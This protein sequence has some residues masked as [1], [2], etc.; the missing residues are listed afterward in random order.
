MT[1]IVLA[2]GNAGKIEEL[3][4]MLEG[5]GIRARAQSH[6]NVPSV[7]E[8]GSTFVENAIIKARHAAALTGMS[9]VGDDSGIEVMALNGA[10]GVYSARFAGPNATDEDNNRKLLE[11]M[12]DI[13]ADQ[14]QARFVCVMVFMRHANDATPLIA[15]GTFEGM[16]LDKIHVGGRGFGYDPVFYVPE[17]GCTAAE[18]SAEVKNRISHR[19][20]ALQLLVSE[21]RDEFQLA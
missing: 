20:K 4:Q 13:P 3:N 14:R 5:T 16:I 12:K 10:P 9:S 11:V 2:T 15:Q 1:D 17:Y 18:L 6:W 8:T 19:G 7:E 21:L